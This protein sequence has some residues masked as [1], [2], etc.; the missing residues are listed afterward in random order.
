LHLINLSILSFL[1]GI[2]GTG[3]GGLSAFLFKS[4]SCRTLS[5]ILEFSGGLMVSVVYFELLP[6]AFDI[7]GTLSVTT[8]FF[9]GILIMLVFDNIIK[10]INLFQSKKYNKHLI[11][12]GIIIIIG[13]SLH[14]FPEGFAVGTGFQASTEL[15]IKLLAVIILHDIPEGVAAAIPIKAGGAKAITAFLMTI[16]TGIPM[17]IGTIAGAYLGKVSVVFIAICLGLAGGAMVYVV[18][19]ELIP[20]SKRI[21]SGRFSALGSICGVCC[22]IIFSIVS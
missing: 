14:N 15:G 7:G 13:L 10:N 4:I 3:L 20:E 6:E 21:Y 8:G 19:C 5:F 1:S 22:G 18:F 17:M 9:L 16:V 11:K 2:A 12:T